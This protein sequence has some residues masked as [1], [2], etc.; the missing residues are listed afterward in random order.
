MFRK[1]LVMLAVAVAPTLAAAQQPTQQPTNP[2]PA[3]RR[4]A[5]QR[6]DT[7]KAKTHRTRRARKGHTTAPR[8][9]TKAKP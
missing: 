8:D 5:A 6:S 9:T 2:P 7:T 3:A 1:T 4:T